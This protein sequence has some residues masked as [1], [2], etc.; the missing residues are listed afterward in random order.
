MISHDRAS[1]QTEIKPRRP[2]RRG[3]LAFLSEFILSPLQ[4]GAFA[5]S[6][7]WVARAMVD[8]LGVEQAK[9]VAEFG[10]GTGPITTEIL[11]RMP[12]DCT[13]FAIEK[14]DRLAEIFRKRHPETTLF[15]DSAERIREL[16]GR[17]GVQQLDAVV[18][19]IPWI[20]MPGS[21]Q[22]RILDETVSMMRPGAR[23]STITYRSEKFGLVK[24]F[25]ALMD[26]K[27]GVVEPVSVVKSRLSN[28]YIYRCTK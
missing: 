1:V 5:E 19:S 10:P 6:P 18:T 13:F 14:S 27:F 21:L 24:K 2:K 9:A 22:E 3:T 7:P 8:G 20:L 4:I 17:V 23:F 12:G 28:A 26:K 16:C 15:Q 11:R 25:R